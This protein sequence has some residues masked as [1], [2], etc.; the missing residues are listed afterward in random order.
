MSIISLLAADNFITVNRSIVKALGLEAAVLLG[1]FA[2]EATYWEEGEQTEDGFFYSTI[3]NVEERTSLSV[4]QQKNAIAVLVENNLI[5]VKRMGMPARRYIKI[6]ER[7]IAD[8]LTNKIASFSQTRCRKTNKQDCEFFATNKTINKK[9]KEKDKREGYTDAEVLDSFPI[10]KNNPEIRDALLDFIQMRKKIKKPICTERAL[11][12]NIS[13][14]INLSYGDPDVMLSIIDQSLRNSWQ[15]F[16]SLKEQ[17]KTNTDDYFERLLREQ[18]EQDENRNRI[19]SA[20]GVPN[21]L[22]ELL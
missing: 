14:A 20:E 9:T 17:T 19:A 6:N 15:G 4:Y 8:L 21:S 22:P 11:R 16:Y 5:E 10:V 18:E 3:E 2:S 12:L 7:G 1:E 13:T